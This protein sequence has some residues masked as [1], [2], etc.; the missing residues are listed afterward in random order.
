MLLVN[1]VARLEG[2]MEVRL[3]KNWQT[4]K[5]SMLVTAGSGGG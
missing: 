3:K 4:K 5:L 2:R 1:R